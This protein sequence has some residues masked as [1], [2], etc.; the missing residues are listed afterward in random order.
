M[1]SGTYVRLSKQAR[2]ARAAAI[3]AAY[4]N[5]LQ[6]STEIGKQY[7]LSGSGVMII[8]NKSQKQ[9]YAYNLSQQ[10]KKETAAVQEIKT[11]LKEFDEAA[12]T[13]ILD[14]VNNLDKN[15]H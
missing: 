6:S 5:G 8:Y 9:R 12:R 14:R 2:N 10:R 11:T 15:L 7:G 13:R 1:P 4:A 3:I